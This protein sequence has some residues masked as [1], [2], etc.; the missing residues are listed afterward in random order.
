MSVGSASW[1]ADG[2]S[3]RS[4]PDARKARSQKS[5]PVAATDLP[6]SMVVPG[7]TYSVNF[8]VYT[9]AADTLQVNLILTTTAGTFTFST[10]GTYVYQATWTNLQSNPDFFVAAD[11]VIFDNKIHVAHIRLGFEPAEADPHRSGGSRFVSSGKRRW[12]TVTV[13]ARPFIGT[14]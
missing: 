12:M 10:P 11:N 9:A 5:G 2:A 3:D 6:L 7:H 1:T 13:S 4:T 14:G 8:P